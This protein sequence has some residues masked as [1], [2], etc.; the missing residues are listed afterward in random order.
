MDFFLIFVDFFFVYSVFIVDVFYFKWWLIFNEGY[1]NFK[2]KYIDVNI[3]FIVK[4]MWK[5]VFWVFVYVLVI[6]NIEIGEKLKCFMILIKYFGFC[7]I[8]DIWF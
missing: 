6:F 2:I 1:K 5:K 3:C 4:N 7:F 8:L